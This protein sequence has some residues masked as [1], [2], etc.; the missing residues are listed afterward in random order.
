[1][2]TSNRTIDKCMLPISI[3]D[4]LK[5]YA[6][7]PAITFMTGIIIR[8]LIIKINRCETIKNKIAKNID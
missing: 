6:N 3:T 4:T 1:M 7:A 2:S 5:K 8:I